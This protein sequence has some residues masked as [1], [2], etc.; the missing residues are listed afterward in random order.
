MALTGKLFPAAAA[1][2]VAG[3]LGAQAT[4]ARPSCDADATK[5]NLA[6]AAFSVEQART[7]QGTPGAQTIMANAVKQL[8]AAK[9]EDPTVQAL[10]LGQT[11]A[12]WL[13]QPNMSA[14]PTRGVL[15]FTQ[16]P[17]ATIDLVATV[18]SLFKVVETAK[19]ACVELTSAYRGG[20]PGYLALVNGAIGALNADKLDSA[21]YYA[22]RANRLYAGSPYGSMVLGS[23]AAKRKDEAKALEYWA[24]AATSA[25]RDTIYRDVERSVLSNQGTTLLGMANRLSGAERADAAR[26]AVAVYTRLLAVPGTT[27][28]FASSGRA[29]MQS[30]YLLM[31]DTAAF[32]ASYQ[33][34]IANPSAYGYQDLLGSAVNAARANRAADAAKLFEAT[35]AQNP[36]NRDALYNLAV[37]YLA[38]EQN[39]KVGAVVARLVAVDPANPEN[40]N[41]AARAYL[42][43]AKAA[44][45]AKRTAIAKAYNDT[46][47]TWYTQGNKLPVEVVFTEFSPTEKALTIAGTVLDRRD[48]IES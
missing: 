46:T 2:L 19:P 20:L 23:V 48:K 6:K 38:L 25:A 35:L 1:L 29:N 40:Y 47:M 44:E 45:A 31:G 18:D 4:A 12:F 28:A 26:R 39:D 36:Y 34:L 9:G 41:L 13:S 11:L 3:S 21:E 37:M 16:N 33:P 8:E 30:A 43:Q 42:A 22:T 5:G 17:E 27:G 24:A 32:A 7:A 15:G 14:T 10:Y